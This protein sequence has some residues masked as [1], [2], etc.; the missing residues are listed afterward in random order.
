MQDVNTRPK[1]PKTEVFGSFGVV[2]MSCIVN[3]HVVR[4]VL[5]NSVCLLSIFLLL[6]SFVD[7]KFCGIFVCGP[8]QFKC[9]FI[10]WDL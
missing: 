1:E 10:T 7:P 3:F 6:R 9:Q 4:S 8:L 2:L 5:Q